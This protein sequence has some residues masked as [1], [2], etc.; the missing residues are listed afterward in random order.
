MK[1]KNLGIFFRSDLNLKNR[2]WHRLLSV[3]FMI[4]FIVVNYLVF[5]SIINKG[6][7]PRYSKTDTLFNRM[8]TD[9][10]IIGDLVYYDEKISGNENGL[11]GVNE[12]ETIHDEDG[13]YFYHGQSFYS[14]SGGT[15]VKQKYYCSKNISNQI[16]KVSEITGIN[17]Y[18]ANL[19]L[20]SLNDFKEYLIKN[21]ATCV[22]VWNNLDGLKNVGD[23]KKALTWGLEAEGMNIYKVSLISSLLYISWCFFIIVIYSS[24]LILI[25]YKVVLYIIFGNYK[26]E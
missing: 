3:V 6:Y 13:N 11:Y 10:H 22:M 15:L 25:Y 23:A 19:E 1:V 7:F 18:K 16:E 24:I 14:L 20:V 2:W 17:Y 4:S 5:S 8:D 9:V 12:G 26:N 21:N